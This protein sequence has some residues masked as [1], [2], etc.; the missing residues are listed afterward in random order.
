M[1][2]RLFQIVPHGDGPAAACYVIGEVV[3]FHIAEDLYE[4]GAIDARRIDAIGR[5]SGDWYS[6]THDGAMFALP[7]PTKP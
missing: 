7:R 4:D 1:E 2:C 3:C 5:M 6:R